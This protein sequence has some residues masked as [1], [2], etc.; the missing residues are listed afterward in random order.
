MLQVS[1]SQPEACGPSRS[2]QELVSNTLRPAK[3]SNRTLHKQA[4]FAQFALRTRDLFYSIPHEEA[5]VVLKSD[6]QATELGECALSTWRWRKCGQGAANTGCAIAPC[7]CRVPLWRHNGG[8]GHVGSRTPRRTR[9]SAAPW[10]C[11]GVEAALCHLP[12]DEFLAY[13]LQPLGLYGLFLE[14]PVVEGT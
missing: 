8:V 7:R 9:R 14:P 6:M 4:I 10:T 12:V 13:T 5:F 11:I 3:V 1:H 2:K